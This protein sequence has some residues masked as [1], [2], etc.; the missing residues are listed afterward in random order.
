MEGYDG[1]A[2]YN[3]FL[4]LTAPAP[5]SNRTSG[6]NT[7]TNTNQ[8]IDSGAT[9]TASVG[10]GDVVANT[11]AGT[12]SEVVTVDSDTTLTLADDIFT[13]TSQAYSVDGGYGWA[14]TGTSFT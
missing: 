14:M 6:T 12:Y 2:A 4:T 8:L 5:A 11:T 13:S 1:Q 10:I 7:S 9:F 3:G